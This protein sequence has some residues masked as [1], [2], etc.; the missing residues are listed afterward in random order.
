MSELRE[1]TPCTYI[2]LLYFQAKL[3]SNDGKAKFSNLILPTTV[4]TYSLF[5]KHL[6]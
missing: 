3:Y 6:Y 2:F 5:F 1:E 4:L